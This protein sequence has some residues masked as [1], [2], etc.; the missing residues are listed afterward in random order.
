M[1]S[2][3]GV[4]SRHGIISQKNCLL[5]NMAARNS[6]SHT[7]IFYQIYLL[8][9]QPPSPPGPPLHQTLQH[10]CWDTVRPFCTPYGHALVC[11]IGCSDSDIW[12]INEVLQLLSALLGKGGN[13]S[14][15]GSSNFNKA[16]ARQMRQATAKVVYMTVYVRTHELYGFVLN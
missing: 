16:L 14:S 2:S 4:V 11:S 12:W 1:P 3:L 6:A 15:D 9:L 8:S 5:S 13:S 10:V 7:Y